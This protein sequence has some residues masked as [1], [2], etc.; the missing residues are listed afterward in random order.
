M[1]MQPNGEHRGLTLVVAIGIV[2]GIVA[3]FAV[4]RLGPDRL[5][6]PTNILQLIG[7]IAATGVLIALLGI[8]LWELVSR[9]RR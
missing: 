5:D 4:A 1:A 9:L 8:G 2:T 6:S 3:P 7:V